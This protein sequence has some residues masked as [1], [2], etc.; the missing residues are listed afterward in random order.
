MWT[1]ETVNGNVRFC[2]RYKDPM[3]GKKRTVSV[4][5]PN[6]S[7]ANKKYAENVLFSRIRS[8]QLQ[9][10]NTYDITLKE[11]VDVYLEWK[12]AN[13]KE[14]TYLGSK[15]KLKVLTDKLGENVRVTSLTVRYINDKLKEDEPCTY[16]E[17][18]KHLKSMLRWAMQNDYLPDAVL[19][20]KLKSK[21]VP[22]ARVRNAK[23]Y[24]EHEEIDLILNNFCEPWASL[25][26]FLLLSGL[27]VGEAMDLKIKDID[28]KK[29]TL[30]VRST[31]SM[32][33]NKSSSTKTEASD[34][35]VY[36]QDE[37]YTF[38]KNMNAKGPH[39]FEFADIKKSYNAYR[40][41]FARHTEKLLGRKL[42]PH[43]LR[44]TH[45]ALLAEA[46]LPLQ[47][48]SARLGHA[49]SDIT[50][51]IYMHITNKMIDERN[52]RIKAVKLLQKK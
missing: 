13:L 8:L 7:N 16:N 20:D 14:Q 43:C 47:D 27:R 15:Q 33:S 45:T 22:P 35:T 19:A 21:K 30:R 34:R 32:I 18:I 42:T 51:E 40:N 1:Q 49:N 44:H 46:G 39:L 12:K 3:T 23:K 28:L 26:K 5:L 38:I 4:T 37:L 6:G 10:D 50:Q 25:S 41:Y 11:L 9:A 24:L 2:E 29:R 36:I 31:F 17:R 52:N 48:I